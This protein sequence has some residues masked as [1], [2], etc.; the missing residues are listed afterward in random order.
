MMTRSGCPGRRRRRRAGKNP[1][2]RFVL[3][4]RRLRSRNGNISRGRREGQTGSRRWGSRKGGGCRKCGQH[5]P[6]FRPA[7]LG[8]FFA[9]VVV[10]VVA[11]L[12]III[13]IITAITV[14]TVMAEPVDHGALKEEQS[15]A[16][17]FLANPRALWFLDSRNRGERV[18]SGGALSNRLFGSRIK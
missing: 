6:G 9:F 16:L 5:T 8:T 7:S 10:V 3:P 14:I 13:I 2:S 1:V 4:A 11:V 15:K 18:T 17:R 12:V